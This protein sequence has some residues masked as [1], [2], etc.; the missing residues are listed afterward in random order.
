VEA[1]KAN[2]FTGDPLSLKEELT[3]F[4]D[5]N[6]IDELVILTITYDFEKRMRSYELLADV[7]ELSR[8]EEAA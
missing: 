8:H 4:A 2:R 5:A 7:F 1:N 3:E 6:G